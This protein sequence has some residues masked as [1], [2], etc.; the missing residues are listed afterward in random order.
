MFAGSAASYN[1]LHHPKII[2]IDWQ[3]S[4]PGHISC[5]LGPG[6]SSI[7]FFRLNFNHL[8]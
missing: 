2:H 5:K 7:K 4:Y 3:I 6:G 8:A 1:T